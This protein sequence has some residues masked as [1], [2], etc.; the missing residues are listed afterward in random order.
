MMEWSDI[1]T[2]A[3]NIGFPATLCFILIHYMLQTIEKKFDQLENS[4][5]KLSEKIELLRRKINE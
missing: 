5:N 3:T 2:L 1:L 4:L